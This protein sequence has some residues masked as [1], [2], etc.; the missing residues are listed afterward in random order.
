MCFVGVFGR[1]GMIGYGTMSLLHLLEC[2]HVHAVCLLNGSEQ[3]KITL[4][5]THNNT[6]WFDFE[7]G[8]SHLK[9]GLK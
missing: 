9:A 2:I 1:D 4:Y 7:R 8:V 5:I 6:L 3:G